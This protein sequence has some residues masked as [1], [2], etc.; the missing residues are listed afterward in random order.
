MS[1]WLLLLASLGGGCAAAQSESAAA[2]SSAPSPAEMDQ[3]LAG[4]GAPESGSDEA[5][6]SSGVSGASSRTLREP[7][8]AA[9]RFAITRIVTAEAPA[10]HAGTRRRIDVKLR[11]A[12]L[13]EALRFLAHAGGFN[14]VIGEGV[15]GEVTA[16]LKRVTPYDALQVIARAHGARVVHTRPAG[17]SSIVLVEPDR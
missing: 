14:L 3:A 15:S 10:P 12:D 4:Y 7:A 1:R 11:R 16:E 17:G 6:D 9:D 2:P 13:Q 8:P 5:T